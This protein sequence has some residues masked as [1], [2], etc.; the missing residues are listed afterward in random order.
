LKTKRENLQAQEDELQA[1]LT[2]LGGKLKAVES[3]KSVYA[4][5]SGWA[6]LASSHLTCPILIE[7]VQNATNLPIRGPKHSARWRSCRKT[8][9]VTLDFV[10]V[11]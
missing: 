7:L 10:K 1:T 3:G 8:T 4:I 2:E 6:C 9:P 5:R 11:M